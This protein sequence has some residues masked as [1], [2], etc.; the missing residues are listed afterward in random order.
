MEVADGVP[1]A[2]RAKAAGPLDEGGRGLVLVEA[3]T[4]R[5]GVEERA[6]GK[7]VWFACDA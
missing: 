6:G 1:G 5:W 2:V 3:V 4:D 7:T